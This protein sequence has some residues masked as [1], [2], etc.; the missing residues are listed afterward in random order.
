MGFSAVVAV[1][2]R[3]TSGEWSAPDR[4]RLASMIETSLAAVFA[5][6][7]PFFLHNLGLPKP[8]TWTVCSGA[9]LTYEAFGFALARRRRRSAQIEFSEF[10]AVIYFYLAIMG[11]S[12]AFQL[13]N[14]SI[15]HAFGPFLIGIGLV[16]MRAAILFSRLVLLAVRGS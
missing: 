6:L 13:A 10:D 14:V 3:R 8:A 12:A 5:C 11:V 2:G 7:L 16:L 15:A 9:L 1:F 4:V